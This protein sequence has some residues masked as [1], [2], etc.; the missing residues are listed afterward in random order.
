MFSRLLEASFMGGK[1][2]GFYGVLRLL[3]ALTSTTGLA[4]RILE[5]RGNTRKRKKT[6]CTEASQDTTQHPKNQDLWRCGS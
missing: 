3:S 2:Y 6:R 4:W 1:R 5:S